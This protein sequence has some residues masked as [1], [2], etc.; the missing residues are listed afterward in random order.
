[1]LL[2]LTDVLL[3]LLCYCCSALNR[4]RLTLYHNTELSCRLLPRWSDRSLPLLIRLRLQPVGSWEGQ[5][6][7]P[8]G[9]WMPG[10]RC[11]TPTGCWRLAAPPARLQQPHLPPAL[12]EL[13]KLYFLFTKTVYFMF[14]FHYFQFAL[15]H[16]DGSSSLDLFHLKIVTLKNRLHHTLWVLFAHLLNYSECLF[17]KSGSAKVW[18]VQ[19][20]LWISIVDNCKCCWMPIQCNYH[21]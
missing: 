13:L 1:M 15:V 7:R 3:L 16:V 6:G 10:A 19:W 17:V 20:D 2:L 14:R 4:S 8:R 18:Y 5:R 11:Q 9:R 12:V 21:L